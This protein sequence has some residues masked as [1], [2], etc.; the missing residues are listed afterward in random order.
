M[1][2][3]V[4]Q[5]HG[6]NMTERNLRYAIYATFSIF[7]L[8]V[9]GGL[10]ANSLALL[11][12]AAHMFMDVFALVLTYAAIKVAKR[13]SN[14]NAT[15]GYHRLEI[16]SAL[17]NGLTLIIIS[18][19]IAREAYFRLLEPPEVRGTEMLVVAAIGLL[20]NLWVTTRLHGHH[21]LNVRGAYLHALGDTLSS[22]AVIVGALIILF[23]GS[24][25][26]DPVLSFVIVAVILFG[27]VRLIT[28][29]LHI[30]M[31]S[32]P[33]H[34]D[35]NELV[36][37]VNSIEGIED[38]HDVHLWSVCSNVHAISAHVLV[39]DMQVCETADLTYAINKML[40]EKFTITQTTFQFESI[41]CGRQLIH[42][43]EH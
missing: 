13:P 3:H 42:G 41:E 11:S 39:G 14:H 27:S 33:K 5:K 32:A 4:N 17:I 20:V 40:K 2:G 18:V 9:A 29:S 23:T 15:F 25:I 37:A 19:F 31:E 22:V 38:I 10:Y 36:G 6:S 1:S 35:I 34:I 28:D 26:A 12:D 8:E 24:S 16:F 7:I 21:D 30:L 43:V